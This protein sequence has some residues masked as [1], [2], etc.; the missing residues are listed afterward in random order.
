MKRKADDTIQ[1]G[2]QGL[3]LEEQSSLEQ[4]RLNEAESMNVM[5]SVEYMDTE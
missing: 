1:K 3:M 2:V 4:L 5:G